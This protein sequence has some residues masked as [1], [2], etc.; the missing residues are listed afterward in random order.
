V[1]SGILAGCAI[2]GSG[3]TDALAAYIE[4]TARLRGDIARRLRWL[5]L[6]ESRAGKYVGGLIPAWLVSRITEDL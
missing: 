3:P 1:R 6:M 5:P 4:R 2:A